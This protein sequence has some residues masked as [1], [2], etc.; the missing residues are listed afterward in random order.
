MTSNERPPPYY[1]NYGYQPEFGP[2]RYFSGYNIYLSSSPPH[3]PPSVPP[4]YPTSVPPQYPPSVPQYV[5]R[6]ATHQSTPVPTIV[7]PT[8][9][10][11]KSCSPRARKA[12]ILILSVAIILIGAAIAGVLIWYFVTDSCSGS[13]I[14]CGT[15]GVCVTPSQWCNGVKDCPNGEDENRCVRLYGPSFML[16]VYS[17]ENKGWYAVCHDGW[18][19]SYGQTACTDMGYN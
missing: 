5:P 18:N 13:K 16:E 19:D 2:P 14:H 17:S 15:T 1:E 3:Y 6:V 12:L 10:S 8:V 11:S 7:Q 4:Q 9:S